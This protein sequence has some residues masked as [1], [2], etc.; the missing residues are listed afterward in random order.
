M[1][2]IALLLGLAFAGMAL[3][4]CQ[5]R[6]QPRSTVLSH[7]VIFNL[8]DPSQADALIDDCDRLLTGIETIDSYA[9]GKHIETGRPAVLH[10]YDVALVVGFDSQADYS[11]YLTDPLHTEFLERWSTKIDDVRIY[12]LYDPR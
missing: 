9:C 3:G 5:H 8:A 1:T 10:D 7:V 6:H 11:A 2:R 4:A 12:D